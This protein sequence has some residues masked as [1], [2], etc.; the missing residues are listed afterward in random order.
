MH[1]S[2]KCK[3][4][5]LLPMLTSDHLFYF[6]QGIVITPLLL[7]LFVSILVSSLISFIKSHLQPLEKGRYSK[8]EL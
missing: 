1:Q 2:F 6:F 5:V 4:T 7:L 8:T 3:E